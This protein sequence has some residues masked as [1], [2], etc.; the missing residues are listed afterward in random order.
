MKTAKIAPATL[1]IGMLLAASPARAAEAAISVT[2]IADE[3]GTGAACSIREAVRSANTDTAFGGCTAGSGADTITIPAG[4]YV[5]ATPGMD[6]QEAAQGD[7]D[8]T[9]PT[10]IVGAGMG[11]TIIDGAD[12]DRIFELA[13]GGDGTIS[14]D[15][16]SL[17]MR[18]GTAGYGG[19]LV[20]TGNATLRAVE[21][22]E[23]VATFACCGGVYNGTDSTIRI[24]DSIL[25][26]NR[27]ASGED[28][29]GFRND[30]TATIHRSAF[31][32]NS[33]G[34]QGGAIYNSF[35]RSLTVTNTT[36]SENTAAEDG[37]ALYLEFLSATLPVLNNLTVVDN[38]AD[39]NAGGS[40]SG[41]GIAVTNSATITNSIIGDNTDASPPSDDRFHDCSGT[42]SSPRYDL[43]EDTTGCTLTGDTTGTFTNSSPQLEPLSNGART[44]QQG[45]PVIDAG[46]PASP[47]P[48]SGACESTDQR[49]TPRPQGPRCDI[50]A[51]ERTVPTPTVEKCKGRTAT[52]VGTGASEIIAGTP[53]GD[54]IAAGA[55]DDRV[56]GKD[57]R[58][59]VCGGKGADRLSGGPGGDDLLGQGGRDRLRGQLGKDFIVCGAGNDRAKGGPGRDVTIKCEEGRA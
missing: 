40:G 45:S 32:E 8:L 27:T 25:R 59:V 9:G 2:T 18:N 44:P 23:G 49:G 14:F 42:L 56:R 17:T 50:G 3:N 36:F 55:G 43:I 10:T 47:A 13:P 21:V 58:D 6:E 57:G 30:G 29:G 5:L 48:G 39:S 28:G 4:T 38:T 15:I 53:K 34:D 20:N 26:G 1:L 7:L 12:L 33:T 51:V 16:S 46:S 52:I 24:L 19:N 37:G 11:S 31:L 41:G 35:D 22:L 54:V